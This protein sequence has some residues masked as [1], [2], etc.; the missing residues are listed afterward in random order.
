MANRLKSVDISKIY[1][2]FKDTF[3]ENQLKI[4]MSLVN[5]PLQLDEIIET[6][7]LSAA[8]TLAELTLLEL[9]GAVTQ[10]PGKRFS[11]AGKI[12]QGGL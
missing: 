1:D 2:K 10:M 4:I 12:K 9:E 6:C 5:Q 8:E 11:I 3:K 7:G